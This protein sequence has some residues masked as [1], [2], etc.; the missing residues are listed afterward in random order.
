[1]RLVRSS[2]LLKLPFLGVELILI[3]LPLLFDPFGFGPEELL[4]IS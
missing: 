2:L 3:S 4:P 1:M